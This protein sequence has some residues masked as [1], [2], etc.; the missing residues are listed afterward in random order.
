MSE[1]QID[2]ST[3]REQH[4][5]STDRPVE[6]E[7]DGTDGAGPRPRSRLDSILVGGT[8]GFLTMIVLPQAVADV[9]I[10]GVSMF[11]APISLV[12]GAGSASYVRGSDRREGMIVGAG[13]ALLSVTPIFLPMISL[14]LAV[15]VGVVQGEPVFVDASLTSDFVL[16]PLVGV[17]LVFVASVVGGTAGSRLTGRRASG[18]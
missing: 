8:V 18:P 6:Q 10:D 9:P 5:E 16:L 17:V 11:V 15:G 12:V 3:Q 7:T 2:H 13:A 1:D 4:S 14:L